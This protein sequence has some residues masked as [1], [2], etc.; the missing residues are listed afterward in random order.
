MGAIPASV[1]LKLERSLE[2]LDALLA[3]A[4]AWTRAARDRIHVRFN[5][6]RSQHVFTVA[7]EVTPP[8]RLSALAGDCVHNLRSALDH[9]V[10]ALAH[11]GGRQL[12][13]RI[14]R[15][16][17]F[18]IFGP[19]SMSAGDRDRKIGPLERGAREIILA[20]QPYRRGGDYASDPLWLLHELDNIDKHRLL[21]LTAF[22]H[23]E[24]LVGLPLASGYGR[25]LHYM[26]GPLIEDRPF[27]Y[28]DAR[29]GDR[30]GEVHMEMGFAFDIAFSQGPAMGE[31][32][33]ET[34]KVIGDHVDDTVIAPL[35]E[36]V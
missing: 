3:E 21:H 6:D 15:R 16:L 9:L 7:G 23:T 8:L 18:P 13:G 35:L 26:Q 17:E 11:S 25:A 22:S 36:F 1:N 32:V 31:S 5:D 28:Y 2:H 30:E 27:A 19:H 33:V 34:I 29:P 24:T 10:F 4:Q 20:V 12:E 14:E